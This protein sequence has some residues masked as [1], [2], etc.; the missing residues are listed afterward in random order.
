MAALTVNSVIIAGLDDPTPEAAADLGDTFVNSGKTFLRV[1]EAG[2]ASAV[3]TIDS[4]VNCNQGSDHDIAVT[5]DDETVWIGP[6]S[7]NR[8]NNSAGAAS[9]T[10]SAHE[11]LTVTVFK[12]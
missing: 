12:L 11:N 4:L 5:V 3:V 6:F 1:T 8:F 7:P 2:V 10:Y 9:I